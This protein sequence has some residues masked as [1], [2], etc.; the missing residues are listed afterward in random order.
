MEVNSTMAT[1]NHTPVSGIYIISNTKNLKVYIGQAQNIAARWRSHKSKLKRGVHDNRH[2]QSAWNKYGEV[3]FSFRV[4][5]YCDPEYLDDR[6]QHFLNLYVGKSICYNIAKDATAPYR[7]RLHTEETKLKQSESAKLRP[8]KSEETRRKMSESLKGRKL[9]PF[10]DERR[11]NMSNARIGKHHSEETRQRM[12][13]NR[14][15]KPSP[16][17]GKKLSPETCKKISEARKGI[18]PSDETRKK[19]S[20]K[21]KGR[22]MS[23]ET[24]QRISEALK[25]YHANKSDDKL[26]NP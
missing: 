25:K 10:S 13:A 19:L 7:G 20:E 1:S 22:I 12:S 26:S 2:L 4:L 23:D 5:E 14:K 11:L 6:E 24:R 8:P 17:K 9:L 21:R 15:G 3:T 16:H 18:I